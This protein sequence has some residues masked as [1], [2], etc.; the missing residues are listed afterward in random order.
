MRAVQG[1]A[2]DLEVNAPSLDEV[3]AFVGETGAYQD[4][5]SVSCDPFLFW[6][7]LHVDSCIAL[8][9]KLLAS[10]PASQASVEHVFS[11]ADWLATNRER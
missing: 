3:L 6:A 4:S 9:G 5:S 1:L 11:T 7:T 8:L 2:R 10:I